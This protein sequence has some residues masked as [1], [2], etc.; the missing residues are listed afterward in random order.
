MDFWAHSENRQGEKETLEEH[1]NKTSLLA[2]RYA[3]DFDEGTAG[4]WLGIFHDAGKRSVLF[5]NV[6]KGAEHN[7]NHAAAGAVLLIRF[8]QLSRVI[9]A[10]HDG[11]VWNIDSDLMRS[12][13][14]I[15][16][17]DTQEG[18]RFSVTGKKEYNELSVFMKS[19]IDI[20][21]KPEL[22][23]DGISHYSNLPEMLHSRM[24]LSCLADADYTATASHYEPDIM[25]MTA[26][27]SL[28]YGYI[29]KELELFRDNLKRT[30]TA[31]E[32]IN[33]IRDSVYAD[34]LNAA[35][36]QPGLFT[37]S[38]PTGTGKTL[39]L[40]AFAVKH[41]EKYGK[42]R[43]IVVL[44][45]L[46][47]ISQNAAV[48]RKICGDILEAHS[49]A[50]YDD[51]DELKLLSEN[52]NSSLTITTSVRFFEAFFKSRPSDLRFL[53]NVSN[54]VI[55]FDEAQ[56]IPCELA[57]T[58]LETL[59]MLCETF[60]CTVLM[61]TAT[62]P[63]FDIR[64]DIIYN[65]YEII[66]SPEKLYESTR[67][68]NV[69]WDISEKTPLEKIAAE[70]SELDSVCC[71]LNRKD[72]V[73]RLFDILREIS[74]SEECFH[75]ST[76][77]CKSHRDKVIAEITDRLKNGNK[78]RLVSTSCIEAGVDLDFKNMYRSLAPLESIV[79][80]A[81]RC[82]RNGRG[83]GKMKIFVPDEEKLY[84]MIS[85]GNAAEKVKLIISRHEIDICDPA[86]IR[87]YYTELFS[88]SNYDHDKIKLEEAINDH[89]FAEAEKQYRFIPQSGV[90]VIV[91]YSGEKQLYDELCS[92]ARE[93]GISKKWMRSAA[94]ITVSCYFEDKVRD[95]SEK[96]FMFVRGKKACIPGWYI[97]T[98]D[99]CYDD[100]SGL[101]F[102][103]EDSFDF[104]I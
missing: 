77:M 35:E 43:I 22:H 7:V 25:D 75:I 90:N 21:E 64:K 12:V 74:P 69:I 34:C 99:I 59:R 67:R 27:R 55:V 26:E 101:H 6:L 19:L 8:K 78:C 37:L 68:V 3:N 9:Y 83:N 23:K 54:S 40:L 24:L 29:M 87:E 103:D 81:G 98:S 56:S 79:Q 82:N 49:M 73:R 104:L 10:H 85:Y 50:S 52:W 16:S 71:V 61:S 100:V 14:E 41:S 47:V 65:P 86:H 2:E 84:P 58:T 91:P 89:D 18:K 48:Y 11:L 70:M 60:N 36:H 32:E 62:Q 66:S 44:P 20:S 63:A 31:S 102:T 96:C 95:V 57:G 92:E 80:C 42:K 4:K 39:A 17:Y 97:L 46:S 5:Q 30:S 45:F 76:D 38:A 28:D 53:H 94:P 1:L 88:D 13:E 51:N 15:G 72:H 93:K 33:R